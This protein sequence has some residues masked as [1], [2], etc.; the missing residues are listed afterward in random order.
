MKLK[1]FFAIA[2]ALSLVFLAACGKTSS[3]EKTVEAYCKALKASDAKSMAKFV[4]GD[5]KDARDPY[6]GF[7]DSVRKI[8]KANLEQ[9]K[10]EL[11][12]AKTQGDTMLVSVKFEYKSAENIFRATVQEFLKRKIAGTLEFDEGQSLENYLSKIF[13]EQEKQLESKDEKLTVDFQCTKTSKGWY[14]SS[15]DDEIN[16]IIFSGFNEV[17]NEINALFEIDSLPLK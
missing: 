11:G 1:S 2:L 4:G 16:N 8:L 5:S 10:Y 3:P 7:P 12:S 6:E 14:I 13:E 15:I 17:E 9:M